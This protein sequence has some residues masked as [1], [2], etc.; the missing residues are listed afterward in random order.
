MTVLY[1]K[2]TMSSRCAGLVLIV[3]AF[4]AMALSLPVIAQTQGIGLPG[5]SR[6]TPL[7]I[8]ADEGIEWQQKTK[9]YIARGNARAAQGDVAVHADTLT[10]YYRE[11]QDGG[12]TIWRIDAENNVRIVST[13]QSAFGDTG[14]TMS[15][16]V[17]LS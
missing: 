16:T 4:A 8:N 17:S 5:Q 3:S 9:A 1:R 2:A 15:I 10:A 11:K 13:T 6:D 14:V 12:T 7:E